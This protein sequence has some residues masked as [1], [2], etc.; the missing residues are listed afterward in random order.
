[1]PIK[2]EAIVGLYPAWDAASAEGFRRCL[3]EGFLVHH[4]QGPDPL[5]QAPNGFQP[6]H[7]AR[8]QSRPTG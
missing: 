7:A 1:V 2:A 6:G 3:P 5:V 4:V 8:L